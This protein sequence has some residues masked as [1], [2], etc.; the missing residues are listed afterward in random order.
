MVGGWQVIIRWNFHLQFEVAQKPT[1][2]L[3]NTTLLNTVCTFSVP[4][5][6][7]MIVPAEASFG[8]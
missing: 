6:L 7:S 2:V 1:V 5:V 3:I 8:R 4:T